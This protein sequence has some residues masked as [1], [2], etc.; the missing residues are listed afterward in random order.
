[1]KAHLT[2]EEQLAGQRLDLSL[3]ITTCSNLLGKEEKDQLINIMEVM[4]KESAKHGHPLDKD[5]MNQIFQDVIEKVKR[6]SAQSIVFDP[7]DRE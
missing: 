3:A 6:K 1:M 2:H 5:W 4:K 7:E